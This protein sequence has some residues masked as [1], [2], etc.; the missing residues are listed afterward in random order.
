MRTDIAP[1]QQTSV[2][3]PQQFDDGFGVVVP[4]T[5]NSMVRG[6]IMRFK[7][8]QFL[9]DKTEIVEMG[10]ELVV[11]SLITAWV[12]WIDSKPVEHRV[13]ASGEQH[14]YRSA[15][16]DN[17]PGE[18]PDGLDGKP[19]D[20]WRDSRYLHLVDDKSAAQYTFTSSTAGGLIAISELVDQIALY[21]RVHPRAVPVITL[22]MAEM[23]TKFGLRNRPSF[24]VVN[25]VEPAARSPAPKPLPAKLKSAELLDDNIP[26]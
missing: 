20:V 13:T 18:W 19:A 26:F 12:K 15:L 22:A 25:W 11:T 6:K 14:P 10:T 4:E 5:G 2:A 21:R 3:I 23:K 9:V 17:D 8:D 24:K 7:D 16:P 1:A